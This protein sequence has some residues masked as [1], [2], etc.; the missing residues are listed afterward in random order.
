MEPY[1]GK[2]GGARRAIAEWRA[3]GHERYRTFLRIGVTA[4]VVS[5]LAGDGLTVPLLLGLGAHPAVATIIGVLP[6]AFSV[7]Q[8]RVPWLLDRTDGDLRRVTL[9]ILAVGETRGFL[10]ALFTLLGWAGWIPSAVAIVGIGVV[11]SLGGAATT[12]GGTNLLAWYGA[13]LPDAE[14]R[15]AAPRVMGLTLG[16]GAI[17]LLPVAILVQVATAALGVRIYALVFVVA[18]IAGIFELA[19][20]RRLPRP[21]RVRVARPKAGTSAVPPPVALEPFIRSILFAGFGAGLGPYLSIYS[22]SVLGLPPSFAILLSALASGASLI[23]ATVVGGML[24][25]SS[26]S[27]TLR[28]SYVMRGGSMFLGLLAFPGQPLAWLVLCAIAVIASAGAAAATLASNERLIRIAGGP[29]LIGAQGRFVAANA[30][31]MTTGQVANG[32]ILALAPL[33]YVTFAGL[34]LVSGATRM[35]VASRAEVSATWGTSTAA[36]RIE[37]LRAAAAKA[38][39]TANAGATAQPLLEEP[40]EGIVAPPPIEVAPEGRAT[41][42]PGSATGPAG[43][44]EPTGPG[45]P[46]VPADTTEPTGRPAPP[47]P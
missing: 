2:R 15:F 9:V 14:R 37:D 21:G 27:R 25:R 40:A 39:A 16:L 23:T 24:A 29:A 11:M 17:L 34:F 31:G 13:I 45:E 32:V 7:A 47:S 3:F 8:L 36:F 26:A 38:G 41:R 19:V 18:G 44:G 10:L 6:T 33:S 46:T 12:I 35:V 30:I 1:Q 22:I 42:G 28:I 5:A 43:A 20:I 4:A